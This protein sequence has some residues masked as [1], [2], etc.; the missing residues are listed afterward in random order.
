MMIAHSDI[1]P[2]NVLLKQ[3]LPRVGGVLTAFGVSQIMQEIQNIVAG[4]AASNFL[5]V[6]LHHATPEVLQHFKQTSNR[7]CPS[8][9]LKG[10][11]I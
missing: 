2:Q 6:S 7:P 9:E 5:G 8:M 11:D 10:G 4:M 3:L 1:E